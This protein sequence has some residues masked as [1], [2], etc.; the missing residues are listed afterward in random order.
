MIEEEIK[1]LS[2]KMDAVK[3]RLEAILT[4]VED[5]ENNQLGYV[6][7][8]IPL[9]PSDDLEDVKGRVNQIMKILQRL[10]IN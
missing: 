5:L 1:E 3:E 2:G 10:S 6:D 9:T 7:D 8:L 4:K